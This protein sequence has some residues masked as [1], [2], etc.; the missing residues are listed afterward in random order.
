MVRRHTETEQIDMLGAVKLTPSRTSL[1]GSPITQIEDYRAQTAALGYV[2]SKALDHLALA[3]V[4]LSSEGLILE[5][6]HI[7]NEILHQRDGIYADRNR[8]VCTRASANSALDRII[9]ESAREITG[10][11]TNNT[12]YL[13]VDRPSHKRPLRLAVFSLH[14]TGADVCREGT[15]CVLMFIDSPEE[16]PLLCREALKN[17]Y[18]VSNAQSHVLVLILQGFKQAEIANHLGLSRNTIKTHEREIYQILDVHS[19]SELLTL[20]LPN[21]GLLCS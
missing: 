21:A 6:N 4:S 9:S 7:A 19:R 15:P 1:L 11:S 17:L 20:V 18:G 14:G 13:S 5:T 3:A 12:R 2:G 16:R 8:L 10:H